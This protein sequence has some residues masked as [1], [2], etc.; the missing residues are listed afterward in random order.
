[1]TWARILV[2]VAIYRR[3]L[4]GQKPAIYRNLY[5]KTAPA[6]DV[7]LHLVKAVQIPSGNV[8]GAPVANMDQL[9]PQ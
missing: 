6:P 5:E 9:W 8:Q 3:L 2:Q 1:M 7:V 4:I